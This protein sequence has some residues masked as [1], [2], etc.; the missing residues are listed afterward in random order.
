[1]EDVFFE[2]ID[3]YM[4]PIDGINGV[5]DS[6]YF[7]RKNLSFA[8]A[9][10]YCHPRGG[11]YGKL[12]NYPDPSGALN[13]FGR[14]YS[15]TNKRFV[16]GSLELIPISEQLAIHYKVEPSLV[17]RPKPAFAEYHAVFSL[18]DCRGYFD[19]RHS[20]AV[21]MEL[22]PWIGAKVRGLS[23]FLQTPVDNL[24]TTGSLAYG[25]MEPEN[26]DIDLTICGSV[27]ENRRI[28][29]KIM[30]WLKESSHQ[31]IEFGKLWPMR[32]FYDGTLIC[33]FFIYGKREE[34][35]LASFEMDVIRA[36]V[37]FSGTVSDD[38]H[39][40][41]LPIF[42]R[43]EQVSCSGESGLEMPLI[44]YDSSVRGE[45]MRGDVLAGKGSLVS[46]RAKG[47]EYRALL[48]TNGMAITKS[49]QAG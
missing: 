32:F 10:G 21:A 28:L 3:K 41:Y 35:P 27:S 34:I 46:V 26:E 4:L 2:T 40:I 24:G 19:H 13:I 14:R 17:D 9:Q 1:M 36:G 48:V 49:G 22:H 30:E 16:N 38:S 37:P 8:F 47:Q 39:A 23:E 25:R 6:T 12:I 11:F 7:L 33:P 43:M 15:N 20:L 31:V 42:L 18:D 5:A 29:S 44:I 45:F